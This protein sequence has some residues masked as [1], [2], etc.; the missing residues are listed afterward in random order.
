MSLAV[1]PQVVGKWAPGG[2]GFLLGKVIPPSGV[3]TYKVRPAN[4]DTQEKR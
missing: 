1:F 3:P 2:I 4:D